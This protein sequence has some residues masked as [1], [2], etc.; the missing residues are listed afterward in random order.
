M[1]DAIFQVLAD[2]GAL[3]FLCGRSHA[4]AV[5]RMDLIHRGR[6]FQFLS[7]VAEYF[8]VRVAVEDAP[9]VRIHY[10]DHVG[11]VFADQAEKFFALGHTVAHTMNLQLLKDGVDVENQYQCNQA[12]HDRGK[13]TQ[14]ELGLPEAKA[15]KNERHQTAQ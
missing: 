15:G 5:F 3:R 14:G 6:I 2:A 7:G 11:R 10:G 1:T 4:L 13:K 9:A 8:L 12:L